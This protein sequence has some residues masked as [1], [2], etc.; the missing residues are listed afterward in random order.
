MHTSRPKIRPSLKA[1]A[2]IIMF[3]LTS[4]ITYKNVP[5]WHR[6]LLRIVSAVP[7]VLVGNKADDG[8]RKLRNNEIEFPKE[9]EI[10]F[11]EISCLNRFQ[12]ELPI[13]HLLRDLVGDQSLTLASME[14]DS[15]LS[16]SQQAQLDV[17]TV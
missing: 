9:K 8:D 4:R 3:D 13:L 5:K 15:Q 7:V 1:D 6:D 11:F 14:Q 17:E 10:P 12:V 2:A 16:G